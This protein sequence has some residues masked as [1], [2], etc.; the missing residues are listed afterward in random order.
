MLKDTIPQDISNRC[1]A[2]GIKFDTQV[3]KKCCEHYEKLFFSKSNYIQFRVARKK[4]ENSNDGKYQFNWRSELYQPDMDSKKVFDEIIQ[5]QTSLNPLILSNDKDGS[6]IGLMNELG[7]KFPTA[8]VGIDFDSLRGF[9]K[10]WHFGRYH[11]KDM[12]KLSFAPTSLKKYTDLFLQHGL[13]AIFCT[14]VDFDKCSMN[15]YY[16]WT[17]K[18]SKT[19]DDVKRI[20]ADLNFEYPSEDVMESC[21][22]AASLAATFSWKSDNIERICF[23]IPCQFPGNFESIENSPSLI[24]FGKNHVHPSLQPSPQSFLGCSLG[25]SIK[26]MYTKLE[27]DYHRSYYRFLGKLVDYHDLS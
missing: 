4:N 18:S 11:I 6:L 25:Q 14:G 22:V 3:I 10:L 7:E 9:S 12:E 26:Q 27:T 1:G 23:Y 5:I 13:S 20:L 15:I 16:S 19:I 2:L 8:S 21:S 17:E 24:D